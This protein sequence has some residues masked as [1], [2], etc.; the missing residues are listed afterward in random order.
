[1]ILPFFIS[2]SICKNKYG[3]L[4]KEHLPSRML[5]SLPVT[6][7]F[8]RCWEALVVFVFG[9]FWFLKADQKVATKTSEVLFPLEAWNWIASCR[10]N[11]LTLFCHSVVINGGC[12]LPCVRLGVLREISGVRLLTEEPQCRIQVAQWRCMGLQLRLRPELVINQ[13][14]LLIPAELLPFFQHQVS[15]GYMVILPFQTEFWAQRQ[16]FCEVYFWN[17]GQWWKAEK[18]FLEQCQ[19]SGRLGLHVLKSQQSCFGGIAQSWRLH[20][21]ISCRAVNTIAAHSWFAIPPC[22]SITYCRTFFLNAS[23]DLTQG[24]VGK[25]RSKNMSWTQYRSPCGTPEHATAYFI[26]YSGFGIAVELQGS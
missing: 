26:H 22:W 25:R 23:W 15:R 10:V 12:S 14:A 7:C 13:Q 17:S 21:N 5:L 3:K 8:R 6:V 4:S 19:T 24:R 9:F 16:S 18:R 20:T 11:I 2:V 1:M